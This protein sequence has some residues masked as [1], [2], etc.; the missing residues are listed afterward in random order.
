[1]ASIHPLL[2]RLLKEKV[3]FVLV[4]GLAAIVHGSV[5]V[6]VDVDVLVRFDHETCARLLRALSGTNPRQRMS[7]DKRALGDDPRQFVG[8]RNLYVA[9]SE[10]VIDF[11]G[12]LTGLPE[13]DGVFERA[14]VIHIGEDAIRVISLEDL[15][16]SKRAVARPKD[17]RVARELEIVLQRR[18]KP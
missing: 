7:V 2:R 11:L 12:E 6:T 13:I 15:I 9:T 16:T 10:G 8:S 18:A 4:G 14:E 1:M 3:E 17:L 5:T